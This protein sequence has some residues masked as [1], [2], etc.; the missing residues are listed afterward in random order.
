MATAL[1]VI[2]REPFQFPRQIHGIPQENTIEVLTPDRL[3]QPFYEGMGNWSVRN[4]FD[5]VDLQYAQVSKS[6]VESKQGIMV[7]TQVVRQRLAGDDVIE[8]ATYGHAVNVS[9]C[10]TDVDDAASEQIHHHQHPVTA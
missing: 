5:L 6:A 7:G 4:R 2:A 8:H 9:G 3:D 1:I 10:Y